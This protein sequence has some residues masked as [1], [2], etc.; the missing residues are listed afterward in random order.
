MDEVPI[1]GR[2]DEQRV[3]QEIM[4]RSGLPAYVRR[5]RQVEEA[6]AEL[7]DLCRAQRAEW[8]RLV[9]I[10]LG[11][12][13]ALAGE[14]TALS[15][16]LA[17]GQL[18]VLEQLDAALQPRLRHRVAPTNSPRPLRRALRE[19]CEGLQRF[20]R[21]WEAMV[22][23][24]DLTRVN[25]LRDGYNRY[26]LLEKE[27]AVRSPRVARLGFVPLPPLTPADIAALLPPLPVPQLREPP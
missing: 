7:L 9:R 14:W 15:P 17:D 12:L 22:P 25:E 23:T 11:I 1:V 3:F 24:I 8:L 16:W 19:L 13:H 18:A 20:N 5:G 26:Y 10:Q 21:R 4:G 27:C 6:L 2:D